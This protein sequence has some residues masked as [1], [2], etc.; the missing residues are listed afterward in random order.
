MSANMVLVIPIFNG[1]TCVK[2]VF[3]YNGHMFVLKDIVD[4]KLLLDKNMT[5]FIR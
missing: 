1:T 4:V 3:L 5:S 2:T